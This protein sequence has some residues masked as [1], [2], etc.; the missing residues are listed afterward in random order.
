MS[1]Q[2]ESWVVYLMPIRGHET[3]MRAVCEQGEWNAMESLN[4]GR[5]TLV[6]S[7]IASE[8]QA[9]KL[10]RGTSGDRPPKHIAR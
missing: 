4:P 1:E 7:G 5:Y 8:A 6:Q 2:V 10:A 3:P 9:E